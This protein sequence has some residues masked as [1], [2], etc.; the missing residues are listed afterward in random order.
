MD[1]RP[2]A[3]PSRFPCLILV[4][5][6]AILG[7]AGCG[8]SSPA[9]TLEQARRM[10]DGGHPEEA[11]TLL[12][13]LVKRFPRDFRSRYE[14]AL[15]W[16]AARKEED[17]LAEA[18]SAIE[19]NPASLDARLLRADV[20]VALGRDDEALPELRLVG[21][22]DPSRAGIHRRIAQIQARAGRVDLM[23]VQYEKELAINPQDAETLTDIGVHFYQSGRLDEASERLERAVTVQPKLAR[24]RQYLGEVRIKQKRYSEGLELQKSALADDPGNAQLVV[25]HAAALESYGDPREAETVLKAA[26]DRGLNDPR[27][28]VQLGK[29]YREWLKF[30]DAVAILKR[31][32]EIAPGY[33]EAHFYL[34][35]TYD[36][37]GRDDLA[38][39]EFEEA[40]RLA[41]FDPYAHYYV[42]MILAARGRT[43]EA[44]ARFRR[45]IELRGDNPKPHYALARALQKIGRADEAERELAVHG[46]LLRK[47]REGL[48]EGVATA[49]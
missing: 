3:C 21:L 39:H 25:N 20:L 11:A 16:H 35:R 5:M 15:A 43:D 42:G 10:R 29:H 32:L 8:D 34:A 13:D 4:A 33:A 6:L 48:H 23:L 14:L 41:P 22:N 46:E 12:V 40:G 18:A 37:Q 30:D 45:S 24:A 19:I 26:L 27:I 44:I 17:A 31:A 2:T 28:Y 7:A 47:Q 1:R 36:T 49:D 38:L 9:A